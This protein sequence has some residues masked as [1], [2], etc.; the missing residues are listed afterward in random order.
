[1]AKKRETWDSRLIFVMAAVGS[2]VGLGN[3]WRFPYT[4]YKYGGGAFLIPFFTA[5]FTAGVPLMILEF[6]LGHRMQASAPMAFKSIRKKYEWIGWFAVLVGLF[7]M[8]YYGVVM[9]WCFRYLAYAF[10]LAWGNNTET[11]FYNDVLHLSGGIGQIGAPVA[12]TLLGL[13]LCWLGVFFSIIKGVKSVGKVVMWTVPV[14]VIIL[15]VFVIRGIT[16]PG[17]MDGLS[18]YLTPNLKALLDWEVWLQ[19]YGQ[20]FFSLSIGFGV[21]IAYGS[22]LPEDSDITNNAFI[23][24]LADAGICFMAGFAVFSTL[25]Y[26]AFTE[27]K[28]VADVVKSGPGL[29]FVTYPLIINKLH[30]IPQVFGVMFFLLLLTLGI[31]SAFSL[32]EAGVAGA[33]DKWGFNRITVNAAISFL[34]FGIGVLYTTHAGLY[35]LD[36]VDFYLT[37]YGLAIVGILE[38]VLVGY[39]YGADKIREHVNRTSD[40]KIGIW[41]DLCIKVVTPIILLWMILAKL[42]NVS[43]LFAKLAGSEHSA[44]TW[45]QVLFNPPYEGYPAWAQIAGGWGLLLALFAVAL[46]ITMIKQGRNNNA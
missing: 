30:F 18:Y 16:L 43:G 38:C 36:I 35:W 15:L 14:P 6:G 28:E 2:A 26:L 20:V 21:M 34:A 32:V 31:D 3:V 27:G 9:G 8:T 23:T 41:W 44:E 29:A 22:F 24:C 10:N 7:V 4:C 39:V 19:A 17:A 33:I 13:F 11:F 46:V 37:N 12:W 40:I 45:R 25:G 42:F 1:M 5:L